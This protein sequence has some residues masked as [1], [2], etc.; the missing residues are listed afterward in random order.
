VNWVASEQEV[1]RSRLFSYQ[2]EW[3]LTEPEI[4]GDDLKAMGMKP[5]P[6]FGRLLDALRDARL[7]GEVSTRQ[8]EMAVVEAMLSAEDQPEEAGRVR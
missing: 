1:V 4:T 3:R 7:D 8:E 6:L 2:V 5:G